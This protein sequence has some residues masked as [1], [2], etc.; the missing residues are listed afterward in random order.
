MSENL[1]ILPYTRERAEDAV[2]FEKRLR[3]EENFWGWEIDGDY[4]SAVR[5]SFQD[6][7]FADSVSLLA[8]EGEN[9]VGRIDSAL[10]HS[11]FD[12]S[13]KAYLDWICVLK[14]RRHQG[15]AQALMAE[16]RR[17]LRDAGVNT[18]IGLIASNPEAQRFY[19][20]LEN[21][22]IQD[23]GIWIDL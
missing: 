19:R 2:A 18:L 8:Y 22:K 11:R 21:A 4:I 1:Q 17:Q 6:A 15:V 23:E 20:A 3:E 9:V 5:K 10:I 13:V 12:G 14:S 16:L 7:R